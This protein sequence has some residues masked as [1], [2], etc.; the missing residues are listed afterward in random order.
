[1]FEKKLNSSSSLASINETMSNSLVSA[2]EVVNPNSSSD[3]EN[4]N[5]LVFAMFKKRK[6]STTSKLE[7]MLV[8]PKLIIEEDIFKSETTYLSVNSQ[9]N[10][11]NAYNILQCLTLKSANDNFDLG[12][13]EILGV[14]R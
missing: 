14:I 1:M 3:D 6:T 12:I 9:L 4:D 2:D 13:Y 7:D 8:I 11:P 10:F 5:N